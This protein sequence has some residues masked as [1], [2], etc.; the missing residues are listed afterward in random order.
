ML[1]RTRAPTVFRNGCS[2]RPG[3]PRPGDIR[4]NHTSIES[5]D[6][7]VDP[8]HVQHKTGLVGGLS[9]LRGHQGFKM[10]RDEV[11]AFLEGFCNEPTGK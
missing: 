11:G 10:V 7:G 1:L 5:R 4:I 8:S 3:Y 6:E 9:L 2:P